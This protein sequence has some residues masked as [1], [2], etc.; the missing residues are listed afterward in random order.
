MTAS[1]C[2][3]EQEMETQKVQKP[4]KLQKSP[5]SRTLKSCLTFRTCMKSRQSFASRGPDCLSVSISLSFS[6]SLCVCVCVLKYKNKPQSLW[7]SCT[8]VS[9]GKQPSARCITLR[10]RRVREISLG[11]ESY[12]FY[13]CA[14]LSVLLLEGNTYILFCTESP[15]SSELH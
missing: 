4:E 8:I 11:D 12:K 10:K 13:F 6:L 7:H 14:V 15:I 5:T 3:N 2:S 9:H 1:I